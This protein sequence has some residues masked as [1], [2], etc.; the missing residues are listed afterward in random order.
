MS[1]SLTTYYRRLAYT[2]VVFMVLSLSVQHANAQLVSYE[3]DDGWNLGVTGAIPVFFNLS[4]HDDFRSDG[5]SQ[6]SSRVMSGFNPGNVTFTVTAPEQNGVT[7]SGVFQINHHLQG[8]SIQNSGLFEGRVADIIVA[9]DF[10]SINIGKG[11]GVFQSISIADAGSGMGVGRF[12]GPDAADATL[13]RIGAGY[14]YA[15]FNPRIIYNTPDL[16]GFGLSLGL[17]NPEKPGG[18][19][20]DRITEIETPAPRFEGQADYTFGFEQGS[21]RLWAGGLYQYVDVISENF[22]YNIT[23]WDVGARLN[24][25]DFGLTGSY[26]ETSGIGSDGLIGLGLD[27]PSGLAQADMDG[28]QWYVEGTYDFGGF[29][30][31]ASYGE[32]IQDGVTNTFGT[33]SRNTNQLIMGF[34]RI[35]VT[36][37]LTFMLEVQDFQSQAQADYNAFIIG[38]QLTF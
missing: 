16:G 13:G 30:V 29:I 18:E 7:V 35:M 36:D 33:F 11:L 6:F 25:A 21:L 34:T 26:S 38:A 5:N 14:T 31:G 3:S 24:A 2:L 10:G 22:N 9:G 19:D 28:Q 37:N 15:N 8:A 4:S 12:A 1:H 17:I 23:G 27:S 32:G 20:I